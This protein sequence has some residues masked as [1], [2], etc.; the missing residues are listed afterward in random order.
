MTARCVV[1]DI[2]ATGA[3]IE[4]EGDVQL[5]PTFDLH[6]AKRNATHAV[7]TKWRRGLE[8]GVAFRQAPQP[9]APTSDVEERL[10][11]LEAEMR[12]L[13]ALLS[14]VA[15]ALEKRGG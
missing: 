3:R 13:R 15:A 12:E 9:G 2:S 5:P 1:K 4:L 8:L 7:E 14:Q 10:A 11:K 6:I